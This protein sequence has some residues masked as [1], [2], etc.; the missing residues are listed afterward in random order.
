M[1]D[2]MIVSGICAIELEDIGKLFIPLLII[3]VIGGIVILWY[4]RFACNKMY[5]EYPNEAFFSIFGM[6]TGTASTRMI[7]LREIIRSLKLQQPTI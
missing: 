7:L 1:F 6:L 3:C 2:I 4:V 5:P